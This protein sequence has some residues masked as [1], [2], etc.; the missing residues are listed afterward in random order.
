[1]ELKKVMLCLINDLKIRYSIN[2]QYAR[3]DNARE[4]E[5]FEQGC[6]QEVMGIKFIYTALGT[7][8][9]TC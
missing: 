6:K 1:M 7:P 3:C 8:H 4:N 2:E 5:D 9:R